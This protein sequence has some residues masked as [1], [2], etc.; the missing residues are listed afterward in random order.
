MC[1]LPKKICFLEINSNVEKI[2]ADHAVL[3]KA[4]IDEPFSI[5]QW[6]LIC[7]RRVFD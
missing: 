5:S 2:N 6:A 3:D 1:D 7:G 4:K